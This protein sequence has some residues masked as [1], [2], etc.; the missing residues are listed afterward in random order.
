M[1]KQIVGNFWFGY[2]TNSRN[3]EVPG[4]GFYKL[5]F[6]KPKILFC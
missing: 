3:F 6:Q 5:Q 1:G 4:P 2:A